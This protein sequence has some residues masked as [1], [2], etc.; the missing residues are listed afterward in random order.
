MFFPALKQII[1]FYIPGLIPLAM[2][3][4][5]LQNLQLFHDLESI[6]HSNAPQEVILFFT[7]YPGLGMG[8]VDGKASALENL[9]LVDGI[10][11]S[12]FISIGCE[13]LL[14]LFFELAF[15]HLKF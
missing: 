10:S 9:V 13:A 11:Y 1:H 15:W 2:H 6:R 12:D 5:N 14:S 4:L 8:F 7:V 3:L